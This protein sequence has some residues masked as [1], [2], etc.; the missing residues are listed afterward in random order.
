MEDQNV[1]SAD[2]IAMERA[3][4]TTPEQEGAKAAD[5][6]LAK[7]GEEKQSEYKDKVEKE[8]E[9]ASQEPKEMELKAAIDQAPWDQSCP[10]LSHQQILVV[11]YDPIVRALTIK[12]IQN[13]KGLTGVL[14]TLRE[15]VYQLE[16]MELMRKLTT[17]TREI[18]EDNTA[19]LYANLKGAR[20]A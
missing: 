15:S 16:Q 18:V 2:Q 4:N 11:V 10:V 8:K 5:E 1:K 12:H 9:S 7:V 19:K 13:V 3:Q 14:N 6:A 17:S 20:R